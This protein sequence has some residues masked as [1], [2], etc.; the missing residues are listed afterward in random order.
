MYLLLLCH[1]SR[2]NNISL[3][4]NTSATA[5]Q[6]TEVDYTQIFP[7]A[8]VEV[9][10]WM[11][12]THHAFLFAKENC[13]FPS[14]HALALPR[15]FWF[16]QL[17]T[18]SS[19]SFFVTWWKSAFIPSQIPFLSSSQQGLY[20]AVIFTAPFQCP[21]SCSAAQ[22][23]AEDSWEG[24]KVNDFRFPAL[25]A[26]QCFKHSFSESYGDLKK[27]LKERGV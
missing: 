20:G 16:Q 13:G 11:P 7:V 6:H 17:E 3:H 25:Y 18:I 19:F 8:G 5:L 22:A 1:S 23:D 26:H 10:S 12:F 2:E 21:Q 4:E 15:L 9:F 24:L 14:L 27:Y